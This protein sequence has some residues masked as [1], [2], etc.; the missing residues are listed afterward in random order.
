VPFEFAADPSVAGTAWHV[1]VE[2]A[3]RAPAAPGLWWR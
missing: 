1:I 3:L 2:E